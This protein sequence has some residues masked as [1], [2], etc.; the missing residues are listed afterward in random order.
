MRPEKNCFAGQRKENWRKRLCKLSSVSI[1]SD[2]THIESGAFTGCD[3]LTCVTV[4][5]SV[6]FIGSAA[7][8]YNVYEE[9]YE[10]FTI[11]GYPDSAAQVYARENRF[12]SIPL[13]LSRGDLDGDNKVT[14]SDV[15]TLQKFLA[16]SAMLT[17]Q[18][19]QASDV[20]QNNVFSTN[21][22]LL[23]QKYIAKM[24]DKL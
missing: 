13:S 2:V 17:S 12:R 20:D 21:D 4:P 19:Q 6:G 11:Y 9:P 10:P 24:M 5:L 15:L 16:K 3:S 1:S 14:T 7:F 18:Q 22:V 23:M 8:G